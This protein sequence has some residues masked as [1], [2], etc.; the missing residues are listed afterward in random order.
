MKN[1]PRVFIPSSFVINKLMMVKLPMGRVFEAGSNSQQSYHVYKD[2]LTGF[3]DL[4]EFDVYIE[5]SLPV[6][7]DKIDATLMSMKSY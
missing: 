1:R 7:Y 2:N 5:D 3:E 4:H 6:F